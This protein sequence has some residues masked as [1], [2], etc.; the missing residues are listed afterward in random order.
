VWGGA[1]A[2]FRALWVGAILGGGWDAVTADYALR[3]GQLWLVLLAV[4]VVS[5]FL[6]RPRRDAESPDDG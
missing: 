1:S 3:D 4:I 2:T 6:F 5:P